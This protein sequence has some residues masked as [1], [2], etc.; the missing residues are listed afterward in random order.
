METTIGPQMSICIRSKG[1]S[2]LLQ[3]VGKGNFQCL[4]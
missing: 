4:A 1:F 2:A 3:I